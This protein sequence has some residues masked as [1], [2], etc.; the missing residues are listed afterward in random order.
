MDEAALWSFLG[1]ASLLIGTV[2]AFF[3]LLLW[4][5]IEIGVLFVFRPANRAGSG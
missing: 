3:L 4:G 2:R 1:A 5:L